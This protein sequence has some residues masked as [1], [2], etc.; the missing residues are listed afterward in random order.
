MGVA[1]LIHLSPDVNASKYAAWVNPLSA[2]ARRAVFAPL[3]DGAVRSEAVAR[4]L[5]SAISLGLLADGERLPSEAEL[6]LSLNVSTMTLREA[7]ADLRNRGLVVTRRGQ[8]GGS[9]V[10]SSAEAL[11]SLTRFRLAELGTL[12]LRELGDARGAVSGAAAYLA[13]TRSTEREVQ[14]LREIVDRLSSVRGTTE[15]RRLDSRYYVEVAAASQSVRLTM[16]EI[17]LHTEAGQIPWPMAGVPERVRSAVQAHQAVVD[18]LAV[19]DAS[20]ARLVTEQ[21]LAE[22]TTWLV[23]LRRQLVQRAAAAPDAEQAEAPR[24]AVAP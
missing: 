5:I 2:D 20:T 23:A 16:H 17:E 14:R 18:A 24:Q 1:T 6:A 4:R 19:R 13:A 12:D 3:D 11:S 7:L 15:Q 9:F 21:H 22:R 10:Q 8:R